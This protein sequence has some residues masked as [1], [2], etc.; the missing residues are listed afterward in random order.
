MAIAL[1]EI[2]AVCKYGP[3]LGIET[4]DR[5]TVF[6]I[7][8]P[9]SG[10]LTFAKRFF[11][12]HVIVDLHEIQLSGVSVWESYLI[13]RDQLVEALRNNPKVLLR[14]TL[15]KA[16]RRGMYV[17]AV[18]SVLGQNAR[19]ECYYSLPDLET[20]RR[21]DASDLAEW[22]ESHPGAPAFLRTDTK[23]RMCLEE[24]EVPR[25]DEGFAEIHCIQAMST[26]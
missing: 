26:I 6:V 21:Y 20:Y 16:K 12:D 3:N 1:Q 9:C 25:K 23:L 4:A 24:F 17:D 11:P 7:G 8:P 13:A 2:N 5:S 22:R 19:I 14:H 10:K 18:R 15:M